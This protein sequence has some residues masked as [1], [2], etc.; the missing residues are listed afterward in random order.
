MNWSWKRYQR[1]R[2]K[3]IHEMIGVDTKYLS[4]MARMELE[5]MGGWRG[6]AG[7]ELCIKADKYIYK[8]PTWKVYLRAASM[9][10]NHLLNPFKMR[11]CWLADH[12]KLIEQSFATPDSGYIGFTCSRCGYHQGQH[13]Y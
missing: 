6:V 11:Y 7:Y 1:E 3:Y 10:V 13:L 9:F 4:D 12:G 8:P 2:I 5:Y